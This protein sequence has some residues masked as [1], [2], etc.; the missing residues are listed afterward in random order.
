[1]NEVNH[2]IA[3]AGSIDAQWFF[4]SDKYDK[5]FLEPSFSE[6][7]IEAPSDGVTS[8]FIEIL[9]DRLGFKSNET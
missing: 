7:F 2:K 1:M 3:H 5:A 9:V 6:R 4:I 8:E